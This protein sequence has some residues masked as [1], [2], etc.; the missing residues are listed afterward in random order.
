MKKWEYPPRLQF[1]LVP[2]GLDLTRESVT[3]KI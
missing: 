3:L 1:L 2:L